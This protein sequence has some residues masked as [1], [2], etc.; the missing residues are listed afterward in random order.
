MKHLLSIVLGSIVALAI[1]GRIAIEA[2]QAIGAV[3]NYFFKDH[4]N[5]HL[6]FRRLKPVYKNFLE[7]NFTYYKK[8]AGNDKL[9]FERRVQKFISMK[10]F[11]AR[12]ELAQ[13]TPEMKVSIAATAIQITFGLPSIY[14]A[15]FWKIL[16]YPDDYYSNIT[17][18]Y[19][20]GEVNTRGYIV[21]SWKNFLH[22]YI[23]ENDGRNLG[24]HEMAHALKLSDSI[25]NEDY[26]FWDTMTLHKFTE[27]SRREMQKMAHGEGLFFRAYATTNDHEFFA[28]AVENFFERP[29]EFQRYNATLFDL[30][31][32]LLQQNPLHY[33]NAETRR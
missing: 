2:Y 4:I 25:K 22:G 20:R 11:V 18:H 28:V 12:G 26:N 24:L 32:E 5:R 27:H 29:G 14:F 16:I 31:C 9:L 8:L 3:I 19:H 30:L 6:F 1:V 33:H 10:E 21:L 7:Q 23:H 13:V 15:H 17:K